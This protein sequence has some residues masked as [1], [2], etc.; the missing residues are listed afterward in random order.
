MDKE[1][2]PTKNEILEAIN[3]F[4]IGVDK[5]FDGVDKRFDKIEMQIT[6]LTEEVRQMRLEIKQI[7]KKLEEIE[8][9]LDKI[10]KTS[11]EDTGVLAS[12]VLSLRKRVDFLENQVQKL[13]TSAN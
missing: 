6:D 7:W 1:I 3:H 2:E 5:R 4:S 13:Q 12:D 10:S 8:Q 9:R 11:K